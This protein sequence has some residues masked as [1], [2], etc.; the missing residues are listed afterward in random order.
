M[1]HKTVIL[2][3]WHSMSCAPSLLFLSHLSTTSLC[4]CTPIRPST[5]PLIRPLLMSSSHGDLPCAD[6]SNVSFGSM[7]ETHSPTGYEPK[8]LTEES[9][10]M[11]VKPLFFHRPSMTSTYDSA[12]SVATSLLNGIWMMSKYGIC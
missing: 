10:S 6:P 4:T 2:H 9:N 11:L 1:S 7:A 12:E 8:G 5:R 3:I